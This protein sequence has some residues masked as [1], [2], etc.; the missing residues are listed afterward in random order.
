MFFGDMTEQRKAMWNDLY[1]SRK[2]DVLVRYNFISQ[3]SLESSIPSM[4]RKS[5]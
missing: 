1:S 2:K 3:Q 4:P 5:S